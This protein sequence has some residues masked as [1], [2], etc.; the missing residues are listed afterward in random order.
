MNGFWNGCKLAVG[1][2]LGL[3]FLVLLLPL[4]FVYAWSERRA[5]R[6][7]PVPPWR[8]LTPGEPSQARMEAPGG[9]PLAVAGGAGRVALVTGGGKRL[10]G[11]VSRDLAALGY[12]VGVLF[13]QDRAAAEACVAA[14]RQ[15]GGE[16]EALGVDLTDPGRM[17]GCL[18]EAERRLGGVPE[19]LVNCAGLLLPTDPVAPDWEEMSAVLRVNLQG[20]LWFAMRVARRMTAADKPGLIVQVCDIWGERPLAGHAAYSAAK[21]GLIMGTQA[22]A[23]EVGP[24]VR[25]NA[26][27]PGAILPPE[28]ESG[29][30]AEGFRKMLGRTPLAAHAGPEAVVLAVRYLLGA[31]FVTGEIL[32]VDGGRRL[33]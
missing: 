13:H 29:P 30:L 31:R 9:S 7:D 14:I 24:G 1:F 11:A 25:V 23:R 17:D 15:A 10:G 28:E 12:R 2:V 20:P 18:D 3:P 21:A 19:V 27:A 26:I 4:W 6:P 32:H 22:L 8:F 16:A 33:Q 5:G